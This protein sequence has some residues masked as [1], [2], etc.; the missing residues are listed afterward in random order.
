MITMQSDDDRINRSKIH[1]ESQ[2]DSVFDS[3]A[4]LNIVKCSFAVFITIT[5]KRHQYNRLNEGNNFQQGYWIME[6]MN[7]LLQTQGSLESPNS[8]FS[9]SRTH[10]YMFV[11]TA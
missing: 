2:I 5:A 7:T 10:Q 8:H 6:K 4:Y 1:T 3:A 9:A 11:Q